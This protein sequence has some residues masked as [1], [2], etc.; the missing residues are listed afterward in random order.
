MEVAL[1]TKCCKLRVL[2]VLLV[3]LFFVLFIILV[4]K[5]PRSWCAALLLRTVLG[6][7]VC[8]MSFVCVGAFLN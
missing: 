6:A 7:F 4:E 5:L 3:G 1:E 2:E 8:R